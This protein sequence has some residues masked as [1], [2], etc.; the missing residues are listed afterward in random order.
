MAAYT[1]MASCQV[2]SSI[3]SSCEMM[4][5][6]VQMHMSDHTV[7]SFCNAVPCAVMHDEYRLQ[8]S[9]SDL[10]SGLQK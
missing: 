7:N 6:P 9:R 5:A 10:D 3:K 8:I 4:G 1:S 2:L